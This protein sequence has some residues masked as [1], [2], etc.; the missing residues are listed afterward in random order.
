MPKLRRFFPHINRPKNSTAVASYK[1]PNTG[2]LISGDKE[3]KSLGIYQDISLADVNT[4]YQE[5]HEGFS[6]KIKG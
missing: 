5:A 1:T 3:R 6:G 4:E 2:R